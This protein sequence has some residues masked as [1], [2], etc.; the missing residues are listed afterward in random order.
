M[1]RY[2]VVGLLLFVGFAV[3]FAPASLVGK[4]LPAGAGVE[5]LTPSGTIWR[6]RADLFVG[7][8]PAGSLAWH[9]RP[10]T[11]LQGTLG[12]DVVVGGPEHAFE[13]AVAAGPGTL[14]ATFDGRAQAAFVN[15]WLAPYDIA[16][17]GP[18]T[19]DGV[20]IQVPYRDP[21]QG[22]TAGS[23]AW[24]GGAVRYRLGRRLHDGELPP[25][26]AYLGEGLEVVVYPQG[27]QTPLITA[28]LLPSGFARI[29]VTALFTRLAGNPWPGSHADHEVV[30]EVEEQLF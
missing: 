4:A 24:A 13:G 7:G 22:R 18:L 27:G 8:R 25:L 15:R 21:A 6:G 19:L 29:G 12:Y 17:S 30:L 26:V 20:E 5:L 28:E 14:S 11:I 1:I 23:A 10:V 3:A 9:F 2:V 16:I